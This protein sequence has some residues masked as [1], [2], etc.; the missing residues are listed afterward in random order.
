[1][2]VSDATEAPGAARDQG[3]SRAAALGVEL[4]ATRG[5][6]YE[7]ARSLEGW[8]LAQAAPRIA[9]PADFIL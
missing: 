9:P 3:L 8:A 6:Y 1:V 2:I 5:L 4:V 7:W